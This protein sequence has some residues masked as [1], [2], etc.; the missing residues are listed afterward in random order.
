MNNFNKTAINTRFS[1]FIKTTI[2]V[3]FLTSACSKDEVSKED[4]PIFGTCKPVDFTGN[5]SQ[6]ISENTYTYLTSG[7]GKIVMDQKN[8]YIGISHKNYT[9]F[10]I[11]LWGTVEV[12]GETL[13]SANHENL[14]GKHIKDRFGNR[15]TIIFPDGAKITMITSG[16]YGPLVS[17]S[18]RDGNEYHYLNFNCKTLEYSSINSPYSQRLDEAEAD[19]ETGTFE[20]TETGLNFFNIYIEDTPGNKIEEKVPLGRIYKDKP[21]ETIDDYDDLR[22]PNT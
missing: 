5:L 15:R 12:N 21:N 18:I 19:G 17:V 22:L 4:F 7:G 13:Y 1:I 2:V 20:I 8:A 11:E 3:L 14:N 16:K 6:S 9:I 10:K